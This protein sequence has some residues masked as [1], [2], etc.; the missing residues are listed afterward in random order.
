MSASESP[1]WTHTDDQEYTEPRRASRRRPHRSRKTLRILFFVLSA[2]W[3]FVMGLGT[4]AVMLAFNDQSSG[5]DNPFFL[6]LL[7]PGTIVAALGG[8]MVAAAYR[9]AR[10]RHAR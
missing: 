10:R 5:P 7:L 6:W 2:G 9:E 3:G 8:A 4:L 1:V